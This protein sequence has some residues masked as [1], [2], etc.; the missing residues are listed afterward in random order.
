VLNILNGRRDPIYPVETSQNILFQ[1]LGTPAEHKRHVVYEAEHFLPANPVMRE[2]HDWLDRY[3][4]P[5]E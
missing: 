4:G 1:M 3:L 2:T 5:V